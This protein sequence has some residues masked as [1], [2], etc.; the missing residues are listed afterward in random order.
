M[1][2]G[3]HHSDH[4][5][6]DDPRAQTPA[7][8]WAWRLLTIA[9]WC[10]L[11][12]ALVPSALD[13]AYAFADWM[14]ALGKRDWLVFGSI[15]GL[16]LAG[17]K[18]TRQSDRA[19]LPVTPL[20]ADLVQLSREAQSQHLHAR[21]VIAHHD[22]MGRLSS[23]TVNGHHA[24]AA[25]TL[26]KDENISIDKVEANSTTDVSM[27]GA[28]GDRATMSAPAPSATAPAPAP[29]TTWTIE[30][31]D[32][33]LKSFRRPQKTSADKSSRAAPVTSDPAKADASIAGALNDPL[34]IPVAGMSMH[35]PVSFSAT[36]PAM[37]SHSCPQAR[38]HAPSSRTTGDCRTRRECAPSPCRSTRP[39]AC[40]RRA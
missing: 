36:S 11:I 8:R 29:A 16:I 1:N 21:S 17:I 22:A 38:C 26:A 20:Q 32:D 40:R 35:L 27:A 4:L 24:I 33:W 2:A 18:S 3:K 31:I 19:R 34:P 14:L 12:G 13:M 30:R 25:P 5:I 6:Q 15:A 37:D 23:V 10:I 9:L 7:S 39:L 28:P